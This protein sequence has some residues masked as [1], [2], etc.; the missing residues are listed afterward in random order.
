MALLLA[1]SAAWGRS[2]VAGNGGKPCTPPAAP[3]PKQTVASVC[4]AIA[5]LPAG[6]RLYDHPLV[7]R[8]PRKVP[9]AALQK[10]LFGS[11]ARPADVLTSTAKPLP[12]ARG[13]QPDLAN[14]LVLFGGSLYQSSY[15]RDSALRAAAP[16]TTGATARRSTQQELLERQ[17]YLKWDAGTQ[18]FTP[19]EG[20]ATESIISATGKTTLYRGAAAFEVDL[21]RGIGKLGR[22]TLSR[23]D[24]RRLGR[25]LKQILARWTLPEETQAELRSVVHALSRPRWFS[26]DPWDKGVQREWAQKLAGLGS[27][28]CFT[29]PEREGACFFARENFTRENNGKVARFEVDFNEM[30][31]ELRRDLYAGIEREFLSNRTMQWADPHFY[32]EIAFIGPAAKLWLFERFAGS[33]APGERQPAN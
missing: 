6:Q 11:R 20:G 2:A 5:V 4:H 25:A 28:Y 13:E 12:L 14:K 10:F 8:S 26:R 16:G 17:P 3:A 29:S 1:A 7:T 27:V 24:A 23:S 32:R 15:Y 18:R 31:T 22:G 21:M 33:E 19:Q 9:K 30:P